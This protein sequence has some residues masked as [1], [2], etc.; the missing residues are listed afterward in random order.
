MQKE[1]KGCNFYFWNMIIKALEIIYF[2][3]SSNNFK[4]TEMKIQSLSTRPHVDGKFAD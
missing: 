4:G 2:V 3:Y 1:S